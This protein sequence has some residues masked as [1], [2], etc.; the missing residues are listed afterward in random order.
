MTIFSINELCA[1]A[2]RELGQRK[3]VYS[4]LVADGKMKQADADR[5]IA[6]MEAIRDNLEA[7]QQPKL[8]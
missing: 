6:L 5:E 3:R 4:R 7:Q 8:F 1:C 2:R